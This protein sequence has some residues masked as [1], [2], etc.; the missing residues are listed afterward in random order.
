ME[1]G[2]A[3]RQEYEKIQRF[4][5]DAYGHSRNYFP[6][7]YPQVWREDTTDYQHTLV[8]REGNRIISLVRI[9]PMKL[10]QEG[11]PLMV[12]GIGGV[13]TS[14][15]Y[16]GQGH[17]SSLM[18]Q[19]LQVMEKEGFPLSVLWGDRHRYSHFGYENGGCLIEIQITAR[20]LSKIESPSLQVC[21]Y[22]GQPRV[23]DQML[24][25]NQQNPFHKQRTREEMA[26]MLERIG[27]N[28]YYVENGHELAYACFSG[29]RGGDDLVEFG[30][31]T[32][33]VFS[34]L[35]QHQQRFGL[36]GF[37]LRYPMTKYVPPEVLE[38]ASSWWFRAVGMLKV[39]SLKSLLQTYQG[40][41]Q[42]ALP[43]NF[44]LTL[45]REQEPP[46]KF[47]W[48]KGEF[49]VEEGNETEAICLTDQELVRLLFGP[50]IW[51]PEAKARKNI[52]LSQIKPLPFF[53]WILDHI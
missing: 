18:S 17:M 2:V 12:A 1:I 49:I 38:A 11:I 9:F 33:L 21:R 51:F 46:V 47:G 7:F 5:E 45:K 53:V 13:S 24:A 3:N 32:H 27:L 44:C 16:R 8:A 4:L 36:Q 19:A 14:P 35:K 20:G 31:P 34:I 52:S 22:Q 41:L 26:R 40:F 23:L 48:Q 42:S 10:V 25:L 28:S 43:E 6:N 15:E 30:G 39:I 29:E 50:D 37:T